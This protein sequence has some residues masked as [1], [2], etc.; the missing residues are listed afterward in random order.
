M[1]TGTLKWFS[2]VKNYGFIISPDGGKDVFLHI[3]AIERAGITKLVEGH[4]INFDI[5]T[6][7]KTGR[8]RADHIS[9]PA[10]N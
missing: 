3:S 1:A 10:T 2:V 9:I 4:P 7:L 8:L 6:D 5:V